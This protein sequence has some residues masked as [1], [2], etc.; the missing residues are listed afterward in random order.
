[1]GST[2]E[3]LTK[4]DQI[5]PYDS[6]FDGARRFARYGQPGT[7]W[8]FG[9]ALYPNREDLIISE[10]LDEELGPMVTHQVY[11]YSMGQL[12][13]GSTGFSF[14]YS[15]FVFSILL[16]TPFMEEYSKGFNSLNHF[17]M[18]TIRAAPP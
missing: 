4:T 12:A 1:M 8:E 13:N 16:S 14:V 11:Q 7:F 17:H 18:Q 9:F 2:S 15:V 6:S 3:F 10:R 5:D